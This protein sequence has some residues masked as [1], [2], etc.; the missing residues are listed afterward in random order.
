MSDVDWLVLGLP[1]HGSQTEA[2][3]GN[4]RLCVELQVLEGLQQRADRGS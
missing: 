3:T 1:G 4:D 2:V